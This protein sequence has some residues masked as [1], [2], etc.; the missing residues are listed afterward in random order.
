MEE[1]VSLK[2]EDTNKIKPE[3]PSFKLESVIL[4]K[5]NKNTVLNNSDIKLHLWPERPPETIK[6]N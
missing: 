6:S 4:I 5:I 3:S 1:S 2:T